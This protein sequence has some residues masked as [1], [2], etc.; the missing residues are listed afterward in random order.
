MWFVYFWTW[1]HLNQER[2]K[3]ENNGNSIPLWVSTNK[4]GHV[5]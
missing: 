5:Y 2:I 4:D 3:W 1:N